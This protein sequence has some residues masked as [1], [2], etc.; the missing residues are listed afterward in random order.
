MNRHGEDLK[1]AI[2]SG[3]WVCPVCRG[4]CGPGCQSCCNCGPCR[5]A[6]GKAPTRQL[7]G[8]AR[9]RGFTNV[10]DYL[11]HLETGE[12]PD[13]IGDR[14]RGHEWA[15]W[16]RGRLASKDDA[17]IDAPALDSVLRSSREEEA[18][19]VE[20]PGVPTYAVLPRKL[21]SMFAT[22]KVRK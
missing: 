6:E 19:L 5:K 9:A 13:T 8:V 22:T 10:H 21:T 18:L 12:A 20:C 16:L 3:K 11:I 2:D 15:A 4:G 17:L 7:I 1:Q 14:K